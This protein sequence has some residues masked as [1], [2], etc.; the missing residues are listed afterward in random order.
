MA[1]GLCQLIYA[2]RPSYL[3]YERLNAPNNG[4]SSVPWILPARKFALDSQALSCAILAPSNGQTDR[5][6]VGTIR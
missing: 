4:P 6:H 1:L 3:S 2:L 5:L